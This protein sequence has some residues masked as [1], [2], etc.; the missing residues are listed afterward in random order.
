MLHN[1]KKHCRRLKVEVDPLSS[2]AWF[3]G[4]KERGKG[5]VETPLAGA[6]TWNVDC[7]V[8]RAGAHLSDGAA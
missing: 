8:A 1:A 7:Y 3:D 6:R 5:L 4:W 2:G